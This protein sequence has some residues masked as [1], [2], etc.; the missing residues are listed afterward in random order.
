M[1]EVIQWPKN[2]KSGENDEYEFFNR[3][4]N[5]YNVHISIPAIPSFNKPCEKES[6]VL[7]LALS[8][9]H[10]KQE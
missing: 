6:R 3:V 9:L 4:L 7:Y 8:F 10:I 2:A 1:A 5:N